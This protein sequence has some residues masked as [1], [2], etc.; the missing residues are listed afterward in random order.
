[1][2]PAFPR[3]CLSRE[4]RPLPVRAVSAPSHGPAVA[5]LLAAI[6]L[7]VATAEPVLA[8]KAV[9]E[10]AD[11]RIGFSAP[12]T[13][14]VT[15]TL[16]VT[17]ASE[18]EHRLEWL[19]G[20]RSDLIAVTGAERVGDVR[21]IGRTRALVVRPSQSSY[22][23]H[24]RVEQ[25]AA[26]AYRCP[27]WLPTAPAD[28]RSRHVQMHVTLPGGTT[29]SGTMPAFLWS[30]AEGTATLPH[31]PAFVIVPFAAA[32]SARPWDVSR[33][34]DVMALTTLAVASAIWLLRQQRRRV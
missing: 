4:S 16:T 14:D 29:A 10:S 25:T 15:L 31:L 33:V 3:S 6:A 1:M 21:E 12:A 30:G 11:A 32:G 17:G 5:A 27:I 8:A 18:V 19:E 26:H 20:T 7:L 22:T 13:C 24:Y 2:S 34:M 28:G 23:I 9:L